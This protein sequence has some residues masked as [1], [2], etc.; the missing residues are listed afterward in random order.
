[1]YEKCQKLLQYKTLAGKSLPW[2]IK[3][4][5]LVLMKALNK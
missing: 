1:M 4:E 3:K 2:S 5:C